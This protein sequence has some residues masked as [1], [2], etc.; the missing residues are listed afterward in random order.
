MY[1]AVVIGG[2]AGSF[3]VVVKILNSLNGSF[4]MPVLLCLHRL[5]HVRSG[6][7]EALSIKSNIPIIE[8]YDKETIKPGK[9]YLAPAN[10]HMYI[11]LGNKIALSTEDVVNHSR[12]SIDLT[13]MTA[14]QVYRE[15]M[16]GIILSGANKDGS[17]GLKKVS[18]FQGYTIVQ[19]PNECQVKTM[20]ESALQLIKANEVL[21]TNGIINFL[22]RFK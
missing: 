2:S 13:F 16:I 9:A 15:N 14:A 17:N 21:S 7:V 8:P 22:Q 11:E 10:Y 20:T 6:F 19:D 18:D 12:P 4:P 5:K 1:K 3:Q